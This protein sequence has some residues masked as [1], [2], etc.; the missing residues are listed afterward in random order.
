MPVGRGPFGGPP[1]GKPLGMSL[2]NP[3]GNRPL[4]N[5]PDGLGPREDPENAGRAPDGRGIPEGKPPLGKER[6]LCSNLRKPD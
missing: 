2:G 4:P 1:L 3:L 5:A 6:E